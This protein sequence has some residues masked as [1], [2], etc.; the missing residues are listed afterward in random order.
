MVPLLRAIFAKTY[1]PATLY[2]ATGIVL[3]GLQQDS[4]VQLDLFEQ[5]LK[6]ERLQRIYQAVDELALKFGKHKIYT[7]A[8]AEAHQK[9]QHLYDRGDIP[10]RKTNR[11]K[12]ESVRKHLGI[13]VLEMKS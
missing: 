9:Q 12:G 3:T 2:R 7:G 11:L 4:G 10:W 8:S 6:A 13:P 5:P 1:K